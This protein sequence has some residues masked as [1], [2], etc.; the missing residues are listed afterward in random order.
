MRNALLR[1]SYSYR[2]RVD[3]AI[4][5]WR[6]LRRLK[7]EFSSTLVACLAHTTFQY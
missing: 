6:N 7:L 2:H 5:E 1:P 3:V 4:G